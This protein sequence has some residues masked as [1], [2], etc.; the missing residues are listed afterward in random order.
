MI[1]IFNTDISEDDKK[2]IASFCNQVALVLENLKL[3]SELQE[4]LKNLSILMEMNKAV[5]STLD[6]DKLLQIILEKSTELAKASQG[7]LMIYNE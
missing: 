5:G 3:K 6:F 7:S 4:K 2:I 1:A